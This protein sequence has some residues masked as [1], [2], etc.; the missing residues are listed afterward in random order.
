MFSKLGY[1]RPKKKKKIK[2]KKIKTNKQTQDFRIFYLEFAGDVREY[3]DTVYYGTLHI[4][5]DLI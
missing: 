2:K 1:I 5:E 4:L 3:I